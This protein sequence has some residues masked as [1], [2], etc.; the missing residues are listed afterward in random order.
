MIRI[1]ADEKIPFLKGVLESKAEVSY[2]P[3][4]RITPAIVRN[5][6]A[7]IIRTRTSCNRDLLEGSRVKFI[8]TATI[9]FDH[10]D[11]DFCR[12][13]G[14]YWTNAPGCNSSSVNQYIVSSLLTLAIRKNLKLKDLCLGIIGVGNVGSKVAMSASVLGMNVLLND[15]PR[16]LAEGLN[17]FESLARIKNEADI[18][19]FHVPLNP[20]GPFKTLG[21]VDSDFLSGLKKKPYII[22][23]SRGEVV[24]EKDLQDALAAKTVSNVILDVWENE[25]DINSEMVKKALIATP[26]IAGYSAE[27]KTNGTSYSVRALSQFFKLGM[28]HW[29]PPALPAPADREII[30]DC[31]GRSEEEILYEVFTQTYSV[32]TDDTLLRNNISDFEKLRGNYRFRRE[33]EAFTVKILNNHWQELENKLERLGFSVIAPNCFCEL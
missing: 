11:T 2:F 16:A 9:G 23:T 33:P 22:N 31:T 5:A 17:G 24:V 32:E 15:P 29:S 13:K 12:E 19:S 20:D 30:I 28:D 21:M 8:A 7:L 27:G 14:I 18:L 1:I 25:P 3:G 26:H 4:E 10:I 6:D